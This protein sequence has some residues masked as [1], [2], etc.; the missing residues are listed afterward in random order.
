M[1]CVDLLK[2][3][4]TSSPKQWNISELENDKLCCGVYS[5]IHDSPHRNLDGSSQSEAIWWGVSVR[6][7]SVSVGRGF[8]L[9]LLQV[10]VEG[11]LSSKPCFTLLQSIWWCRNVYVLGQH[12]HFW[13]CMFHTFKISTIKIFRSTLNCWNL[14]TKSQSLIYID[15]PCIQS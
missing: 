9:L 1:N 15:A 8:I 14:N 11:E 4:Q 10:P 5:D 2:E 3:G 6:V 12:M 13:R 7:A